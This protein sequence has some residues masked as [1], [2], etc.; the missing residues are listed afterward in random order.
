MTQSLD[1]REHFLGY[2]HLLNNLNV[3]PSVAREANEDCSQT[4]AF[5][6]YWCLLLREDLV[7]GGDQ[8]WPKAFRGL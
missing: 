6:I 3:P 8:G 7:G 5:I 4:N 2:R 1:S